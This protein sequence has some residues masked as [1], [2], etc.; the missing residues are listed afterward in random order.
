MLGEDAPSFLGDLQWGSVC[1]NGTESS[2]L[3]GAVQPFCEDVRICAL[4]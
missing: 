4:A 3:W 1:L 2:F